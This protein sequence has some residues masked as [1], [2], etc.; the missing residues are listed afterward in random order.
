MMLHHAATVILYLGMIGNN[1]VN[2][3]AFSGFIHTIADIFVYSARAFSHTKY[4]KVGVVPF[5]L[6]ILTWF[7]T[8]LIVVQWFAYATFSYYTFPPQF[9]AY[10][11]ICSIMIFLGLVLCMLHFYWFYLFMKILH[12]IIYKGNTEDLVHKT[13]KTKVKSN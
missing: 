1:S 10:E 8:R 4:A 13:G 6:M 7:Y 3:C 9:S 12:A 5:L 2:A 11:T